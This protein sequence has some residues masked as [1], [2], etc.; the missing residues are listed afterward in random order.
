MTRR[1]SRPSGRTVERWNTANVPA[2]VAVRALANVDV[3]A[4]GCWISRYSTSTHGYAQIGWQDQGERHVVLAHRAAW[5]HV[6]G[7]VPLGMTI[8]HV[9]KT[10]RCVN[11]DHLR[12]LPNFENA[13]R[14]DGRDWPIGTCRHGHDASHLIPVGRRTKSGERR[15][16][17]TCGACAREAKARYVAAHPDRRRA[18]INAYNEKRAAK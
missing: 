4:D 18:S 14:T 3:R 11:P 12:L 7:Q 2:R 17:L 13:R 6:H 1:L 8:D 5:T 15:V 9:C 16:G 10:R